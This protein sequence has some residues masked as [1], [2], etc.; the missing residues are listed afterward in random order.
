MHNDEI[1][2]YP[3]KVIAEQIARFAVL[4]NKISVPFIDGLPL[5]V[6]IDNLTI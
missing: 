5:K 3:R 1:F 4:P 6:T 2:S